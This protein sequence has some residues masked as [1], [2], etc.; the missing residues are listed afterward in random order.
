MLAAMT[1]MLTIDVQTAVADDLLPPDADW[2]G[3]VH[4]ALDTCNSTPGGDLT[5][6]LADE[7]EVSALNL[8]YRSK[9]GP[10]NVLSFPGPDPAL[11]PPGIAA[12]F[13]DIVICVPVALR[14]AAA[15]Q[16]SSTHHLAHLVVHGALHLLG[17]DHESE[18]DAQR[19]EALE[20]ET[21][22]KFGIG[23]PYADDAADR[24]QP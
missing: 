9:P 19:M 10:T 13:G 20:I 3:W 5:I 1:S 8:E 15:R 12:V 14:E 2:H 16:K 4:G 23:N 22:A 7:I 17:F 24:D 6:R 18:S 21:L 11:L